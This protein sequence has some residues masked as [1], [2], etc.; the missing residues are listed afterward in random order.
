MYEIEHKI[1]S[2]TGYTLGARTAPRFPKAEVVSYNG[3]IDYT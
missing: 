1:N 3:F 2:T